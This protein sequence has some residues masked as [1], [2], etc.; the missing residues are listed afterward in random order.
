[1]RNVKFLSK[2]VSHVLRIPQPWPIRGNGTNLLRHVTTER[3]RFCVS[4]LR[5]D[6]A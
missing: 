3:L 5:S 6:H 1:M 4:G 2:S